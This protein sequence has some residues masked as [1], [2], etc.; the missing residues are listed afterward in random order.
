MFELATSRG[1]LAPLARSGMK[2]RLSMFADDVV[3]FTMPN[4]ID[5]RTCAL[6]LQTFGEASR[7]KINLA[8]SATFP[9]RCPAETMEM[10]ERTFGC[11]SGSF[12]CKYLGL[13]LTLRKQS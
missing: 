13:P 3:F 11:P 2:Y 7:L 6:L 5:L 4:E 12:P 1:M 9:I 8:K 10:V